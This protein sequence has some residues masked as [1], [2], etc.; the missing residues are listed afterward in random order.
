MSNSAFA[1]NILLVDLAELQQQGWL[2]EADLHPAPGLLPERVDFAAMVPFRMERL[3]KAAAR[4][5][6]AGTAEQR[7]AFARFAE[8]QSSWLGDYALFMAL[9]EANAWRDWCEW[10]PGLRARQP[11]PWP[12]PARNTP[13]ASP[14]GSSASGPSSASGWR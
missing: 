7:A 12:P 2:D 14:S 8:G 3:A 9:C 5:A 1:G 13:N 6:A 11:A 4:F 10:E